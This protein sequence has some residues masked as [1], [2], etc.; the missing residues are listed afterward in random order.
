MAQQE[1]IFEELH[2][3]L[4]RQQWD[5]FRRNVREMD[6]VDLTD[7]VEELDPDERD[8]VFQLLDLE[9]ASD[10]LSQLKA[11]YIDDV[12]EDFTPTQLAALVR[13]MA[14]DEAADL[15]S[16]LAPEQSAD[17]LAALPLPERQQL[18]ALLLYKEDTAGHIM[19]PETFRQPLE[20]TVAHAKEALVVAD[21]SDPVLNIYVIDPQSDTLAGL[22]AVSDL[23]AAATDSKLSDLVER[24]YVY[25]LPQENRRE[26]ADKFRRY[27]LWVMPVVDEHHRLLGRITVDDVMQAL[28]EEANE[29]LAHMVGAPDIEEE[30]MSIVGITRMRLPWLMITMFAGLVN[31]LVIKS[32]MQV[33]NLAAIAIFVP[34]ILAM[35]G[36]TGMQSSAICIRGI[37]LGEEKFRRILSLASREIR[38]G[39]SLGLICGTCMGLLISVGFT[40]LGINTG[41]VTA[42]RLGIIV[43]FS[44]ANAMAFASIFGA[45]VPVLLHRS[46]I[47]PAVASGPFITTSNDLSASVIYFLTCLLLLNI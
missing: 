9:T 40:L 17:V 18:G 25:C 15:L 36:N 34:A 41:A 26:V 33:T 11:G 44:M 24:D 7:F 2:Q 20:A 16:A 38:V 12:I 4:E 27:D 10:V 42:S 22:V 3:L 8:T 28:H 39:I 5:A 14:P 47:D 6:P 37:A 1:D 35:G 19:T 23:L 30:E 31:S 13:E 43:G 21:L 29:D 46:K 32:M 45:V